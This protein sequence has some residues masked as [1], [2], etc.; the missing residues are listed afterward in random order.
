MTKS[1]AHMN[2]DDVEA[3][4]TTDG[5]V[6]LCRHLGAHLAW[7]GATQLAQLAIAVV[8]QGNDMDDFSHFTPEEHEF[9]AA[10]QRV[11][12][13]CSSENSG[14]SESLPSM[15]ESKQ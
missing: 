10:A 1:N 11:L 8:A 2:R 6:K 12:R 7:C 3:A 5:G 4:Y 13:A 14:R 15:K 9:L